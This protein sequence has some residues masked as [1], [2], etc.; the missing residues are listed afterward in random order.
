[1][2]IAIYDVMSRGRENI[3]FSNQHRMNFQSLYFQQTLVNFFLKKTG[4]HILFFKRLRPNIACCFLLLFTLICF[5]QKLLWI[6][7]NVPSCKCQW[8][9]WKC[10]KS[11]IPT[12]FKI[13]VQINNCFHSPCCGKLRY[14]AYLNWIILKYIN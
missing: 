14:S 12:F 13:I 8:S 2:L 6:G 4:Y 5:K 3:R 10:A 11:Q 1:M 9:F 7:E